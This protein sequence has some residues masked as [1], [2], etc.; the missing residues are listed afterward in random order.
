MLAQVS[1]FYTKADYRLEKSMEDDC[2]FACKQ[3]ATVVQPKHF[4]DFIKIFYWAY[5]DGHDEAHRIAQQLFLDDRHIMAL[6]GDQ[7][8]YQKVISK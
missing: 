2:N 6:L 7:Y 1:D 8:K 3:L 5:N 4:D